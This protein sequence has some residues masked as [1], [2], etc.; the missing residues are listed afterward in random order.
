MTER[1]GERDR[2]GER[3]R[4]RAREIERGRERWGEREGEGKELVNERGRI[5]TL[6]KRNALLDLKH[7]SRGSVFP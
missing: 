7:Y 4:E 6:C 1:E 5:Y 2:E 3:K